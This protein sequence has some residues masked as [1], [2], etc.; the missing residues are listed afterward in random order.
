MGKE[1]S[2]QDRE[3]KQDRTGLE[4]DCMGLEVDNGNKMVQ[5]LL[6]TDEGSSRRTLLT[7]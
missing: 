7:I 2:M 5:V 1:F 3:T 4:Q 6:E